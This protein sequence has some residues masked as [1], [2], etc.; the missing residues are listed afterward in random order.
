MLKHL[1]KYQAEADE[2]DTINTAEEGRHP[3]DSASV[4]SA[5]KTLLQLL[6]RAGVFQGEAEELIAL[7]EA[8]AIA[9]AHSEVGKAECASAETGTTPSGSPITPARPS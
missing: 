1:Q 8:G 4:M 2:E 9:D 7:L 6:N 5:K 3:L